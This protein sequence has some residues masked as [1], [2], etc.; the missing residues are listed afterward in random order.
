MAIGEILSHREIRALK[1]GRKE[2]MEKGRLQALREDVL[3]VLHIRFGPVPSKIS[4]RIGGEENPAKLKSL[5]RRAL[6][7]AKADDLFEKA[8]GQ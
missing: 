6:G 3:E 1:R 8:A 2:G 4:R 7:C 5:H